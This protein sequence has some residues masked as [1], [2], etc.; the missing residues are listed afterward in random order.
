MRGMKAITAPTVKELERNVN[1]W[2]SNHSQVTVLGL[3]TT[4]VK[5]A[6]GPRTLT[7]KAADTVESTFLMTTILYDTEGRTAGADDLPLSE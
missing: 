3:Q 5:A 4:Q 6:L 1:I 2:I 7:A